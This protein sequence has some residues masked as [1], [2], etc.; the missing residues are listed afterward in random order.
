MSNK[1]LVFSLDDP[2]ASKLAEVLGNKSS[3]LIVDYLS[4]VKE[5]SES[6]ISKAVNKPLNTVGYNI[7]KLL[8]VGIIVRTK[9]F[10]WSAKGKKVPYYKVSNKSI[11]IT[12]KSNKK[13]FS[14]IITLGILGVGSLIVK[15]LS[16]PNVSVENAFDSGEGL[17]LA[18]EPASRSL[19]V[20]NY[21]NFFTSIPSW[22][23]FLIGGIFVLLVFLIINWRRV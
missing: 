14:S 3:K 1:Y 5:A 9:N 21:S 10:F 7:K 15:L 20:V 23:W 4:E 8:E 6:E 19:E 22:S 16:S 12:P 13:F 11:M 18:T 17:M 2:R